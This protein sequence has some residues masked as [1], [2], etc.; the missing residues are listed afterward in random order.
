MPGRRGAGDWLE[1]P[2]GFDGEILFGTH[3][4]GGKFG[5]DPRLRRCGW[6]AVALMATEGVFELVGS[7]S[8]VLEGERDM[9][10]FERLLRSL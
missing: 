7:V 5:K 4:S 9:N 2:Q 6:A 3:G 8:G 10:S 1:N